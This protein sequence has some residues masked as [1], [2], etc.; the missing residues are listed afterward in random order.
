MQLEEGKHLLQEFGLKRVQEKF[1]LMVNY[2]MS[3]SLAR[4][5]KCKLQDL[6]N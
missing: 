4:I 2:T 1:M 6:L 5:I 3:I